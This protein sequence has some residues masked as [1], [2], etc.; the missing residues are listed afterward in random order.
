MFEN[1][2]KSLMRIDNFSYFNS[3]KKYNV[4][5]ETS[6]FLNFFRKR[7]GGNKQSESEK[8]QEIDTILNLIPDG[9]L[10]ANQFGKVIA[11]NKAYHTLTGY[12]KEEIVGKSASEIPAV[13]ISEKMNLWE[14]MKTVLTKGELEGFEFTYRHADGSRK[15]GEARAKL[16]RTGFFSGGAIAVM[17]DI[18]ERKKK[19]EELERLVNDLERSNRELDDYT[20]AVSHDL[21][22]PLRTIGS[23]SNFL[24]EDYS[25]S[26][27]DQ[28]KEYLGRMQSATHRM[29][30]LI[31]DL[32]KI[33]RVGRMDTNIEFIDMNE[34]VND[35][36]S[37]NS[38]MLEDKNGKIMAGELPSIDS[39]KIWVKQLLANLV[40]NGLKF[41]ESSN[42]TVWIECEEKEDH[43]LFSV[44][45]N[46]IGIEKKHHEKIF[47]IFQRLHTLEEYPGTGAG[48]HICKKIVESLG[49]EIRIESEVGKGTT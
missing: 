13:E 40:N 34:I 38:S 2:R 35:I 32:L 8:S 22:S 21:K 44:G 18:T 3:D 45:D 30:E 33:S 47:K 49:G 23:F 11:S 46:G 31:D 26:L 39:Q 27:D 6:N 5:L 1:E 15:W 7:K 14:N 17:R 19:D 36:I 4:N 48:L 43:Y 12:S 25:E 37:D 20:Y 42:P 24:L 10:I 16:F 28:G 41:N 9:I 29:T